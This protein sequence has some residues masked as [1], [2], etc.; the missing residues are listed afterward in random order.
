[1]RNSGGIG[2]GAPLK[3]FRFCAVFLGRVIILVISILFF[4]LEFSG[5]TF[6]NIADF[7]PEV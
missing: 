4:P 2:G 1:M 5:V 6:D 3:V 7:F